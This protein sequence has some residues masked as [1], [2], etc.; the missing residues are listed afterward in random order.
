MKK[1]LL[2]LC[3]ITLL[4]ACQKVVVEPEQPA[5]IAEP[6]ELVVGTLYGPQIFFTSGQGD[7]GYDYEMAQRFAKYLDLQLQMKPFANIGELYTALKKV[8]L[9]LLLRA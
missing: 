9:I 1:L 6:T 2:T 7:S 4:A 5:Y 3:C 8:R